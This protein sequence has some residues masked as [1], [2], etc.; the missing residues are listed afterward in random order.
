MAPRL[1][2]TEATSPAISD[3]QL[4]A[5]LDRAERRK[6]EREVLEKVR[7]EGLA[8]EDYSIVSLYPG[9]RPAKNLIRFSEHCRPEDPV[10][11]PKDASVWPGS[12]VDVRFGMRTPVLEH[13]RDGKHE[14]FFRRLVPDEVKEAV[15]VQLALRFLG[16]EGRS[17]G[18]ASL[19]EAV[20][21]EADRR[22]SA[23]E[24]CRQA[25]AEAERSLVDG[26]T[27]CASAG[28][29]AEAAAKEF[30]EW[31]AASGRPIEAL[32]AAVTLMKKQPDNTPGPRFAVAPGLNQPIPWR[33]RIEM[34]QR[35]AA[36]KAA[37]GGA[38]TS[39]EDAG[40]PEGARVPE[41]A[42]L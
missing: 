32:R 10:E 2:K 29:N 12:V 17:L 36:E 21:R 4:D 38:A 27:M 18:A 7:R 25:L 22:K 35:T 13:E 3:A 14:V 28:R 31:V 33:E 42:S 9:P 16:A 23:V 37:R 1:D 19:L 41:G 15:S 6:R 8:E 20:S 24:K 5:V 26:E 40:L 11:I 30:E 39:V 34:D